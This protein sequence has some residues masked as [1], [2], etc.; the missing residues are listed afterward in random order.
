L[1]SVPGGESNGRS[2][3][4]AMASRPGAA[5]RATGPSWPHAPSTRRAT[6][7]YWPRNW[8]FGW[9]RRVA[10]FAHRPRSVIRT[11]P[12]VER[13]LRAGQACWL[14]SRP[15]LIAQQPFVLLLDAPGFVEI[16]K[17]IRIPHLEFVPP[18]EISGPGLREVRP[19]S[20]RHR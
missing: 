1:V 2:S 5:M 12:E 13:R 9:R 19:V 20:I 7:Q 18:S 10:S 4:W 6:T 3:G 17:G 16:L 8:R 11:L 15:R 14:T